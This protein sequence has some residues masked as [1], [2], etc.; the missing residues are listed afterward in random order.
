[1]E[2]IFC[3]I[4]K[5][6]IPSKKVLENDNFLAFHDINPVAPIHVLII[7]KEHFENFS[8]TPKEVFAEMSDFIKDVAKELNITD[9]RLITNNGKKAGQEVFHIHIHMIANPNGKLK[10]PKMV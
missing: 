2:C 3:K 9:Y 8:S 5:G 10:W 4:V 7:P 6:E 1:M